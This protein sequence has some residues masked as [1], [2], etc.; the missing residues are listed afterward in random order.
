MVFKGCTSPSARLEK[1][2]VNDI[3]EK[4]I[5]LK[6]KSTETASVLDSKRLPYALAPSCGITLTCATQNKLKLYRAE[7]I[8]DHIL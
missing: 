1:D 8:S 4:K 2:T 6:K 7:T 3:L 5:D